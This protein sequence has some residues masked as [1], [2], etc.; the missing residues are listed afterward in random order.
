MP[1]RSR[2]RNSSRVL[3]SKIAKAHMPLKRGSM[4][5]RQAC[6]AARITSVSDWLRNTAPFASSSR[7]SSRKLYISP[8][9]T[10]T[11]RPSADSM[12]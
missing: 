9:N 10:I 11:W 3:V 4:S 7:R 8:L 5:S 1:K 12:G 2:A 6:Q